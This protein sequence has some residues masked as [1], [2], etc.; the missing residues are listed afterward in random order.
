MS[1]GQLSFRSRHSS[2]GSQAVKHV[3]AIGTA[4]SSQDIGT[5]I[6]GNQTHPNLKRKASGFD[7]LK[8][9]PSTPTGVRT[10]L[11]SAPS[12]LPDSDFMAAVSLI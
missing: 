7:S 5:Q 3:P 1:I 4:K 12:G 11:S 2:A 9:L 10:P 8:T 6:S